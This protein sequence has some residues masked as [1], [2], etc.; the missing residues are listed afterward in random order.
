MPLRT[1]YCGVGREAGLSKKRAEQLAGQEPGRIGYRWGHNAGS[2][3]ALSGPVHPGCWLHP[4][5]PQAQQ[6]PPLG[7]AHIARQLADGLIDTGLHKLHILH[8]SCVQG[9]RQAASTGV[10]TAAPKPLPKQG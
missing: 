2:R 3:R 10:S 5:V 6:A 9:E 7:P 8:H 1:Q 4:H